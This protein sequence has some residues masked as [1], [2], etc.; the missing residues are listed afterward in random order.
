MVSFIKPLIFET[1]KLER[2]GCNYR[3][4][5]STFHRATYLQLNLHQSRGQKIW[6]TVKF[7]K[8]KIP[9]EIFSKVFWFQFIYQKLK[10]SH[11]LQSSEENKKLKYQEH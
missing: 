4:L 5:E 3:F 11:Q 6:K 2:Y 1:W 8:R 7:E 10:S 9:G